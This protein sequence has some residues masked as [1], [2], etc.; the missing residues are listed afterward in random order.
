MENLLIKTADIMPLNHPNTSYLLVGH[1]NGT[2]S[3]AT[4]KEQFKSCFD[5]KQHFEILLF[6]TAKRPKENFDVPS[7]MYIISKSDFNLLGQIKSKKL[8]PTEY[9]HFDICILLDEYTTKEDKIIQALKINYIVAFGYERDYVNINL[10]QNHP[11]STE[12]IKFAKEVLTKIS[13]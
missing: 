6:T 8:Y 10:I 3:L 11:K 4:I 12:K 2:D 13:S 1:W 5:E 9:T 7:R